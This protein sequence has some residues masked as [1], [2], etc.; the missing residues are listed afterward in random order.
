LSIRPFSSD[1]LNQINQIAQL[2]LCAFLFVALL[3]KV[4]VD[5]E[6]NSS[7]FSFVVGVLSIVPIA[8][9]VLI[10]IWLKLYGNLEARM[11][12]KDAEW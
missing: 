6:S 1:S 5:G 11:A 2:N 7:F 3:L 4:N 8:L 12:T 10:K 9:P